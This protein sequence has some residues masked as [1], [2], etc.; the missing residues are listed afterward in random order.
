VD[1]VLARIA[2]PDR[3]RLPG[4]FVL[5]LLQR[6]LQQNPSVTRDVTPLETRVAILFF[7]AEL[8]E[9]LAK[10]VLAGVR[11]GRSNL[12]RFRDAVSSAEAQP[13]DERGEHQDWDDQ[14]AC[15]GAGRA[16]AQ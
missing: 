15:F 4:R 10:N 6:N 2:G 8:Q 12:R 3:R 1:T 13:D 11:E 9:V 16:A 5:L 14:P 7:L